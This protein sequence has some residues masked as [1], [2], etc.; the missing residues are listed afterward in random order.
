MYQMYQMNMKLVLI[1]MKLLK[2][3]IILSFK[4]YYY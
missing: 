4:N 1:K 3:L 2:L